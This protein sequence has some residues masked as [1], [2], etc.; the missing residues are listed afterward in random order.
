MSGCVIALDAV[1]RR[2]DG[3]A[4][5]DGVTL[6]APAGRVTALLGASG[7]GKSTLL[8]VVAGLEPVDAG[9]VLLD[10]GVVSAPGHTAPAEDRRLGFVFQDYA[11]FPHMTAVA[12]V[13]FGLAG[14]KTKRRAEAAAWL[15]RVGLGH[16]AD[17]YPHQLSG[18]EQQRVALARALAPRP[19][20]VLLDEPFS[21]LDP[22]LRATLR[23]TTLAA[24]AEVGATVL[25]VTHDA[26]E[27][28]LIADR[29][30][31][32]REG[33]LVQAGTP[34]DVYTNPTSLEAAAALGPVNVFEGVAEAGRVQ[35]P[36]GDV[37]T[38]RDG[39]CLV[40]VRSEAVLFAPGDTALVRDRRP[41][42]AL[43]VCILE[44]GGIIWRTLAPAGAGPGVGERTGTTVAAAFVFP[45]R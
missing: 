34:R 24:I 31:I 38:D 39:P 40:A 42:G 44:S 27:A 21:G 22:V 6:E 41:Q 23:E 18:G 1:T 5:I 13:A 3:V 7:S 19:R 45:G 28:M 32:L 11:L 9:R 35:T 2:F 20:A 16:R 30:A 33:R 26:D 15:D 10:G 4:A 14:E 37:S 36:F 17:A 25:L 43:D 12:N 29:I 8:R